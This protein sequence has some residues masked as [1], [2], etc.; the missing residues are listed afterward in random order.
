MPTRIK[1]FFLFLNLNF[2]FLESSSFAQVPDRQ[3]APT[4]PTSQLPS[5]T[6]SSLVPIVV[7]PPNSSPLVAGPPT[8]S[9]AWEIEGEF[10]FDLRLHQKP[11]SLSG[12][13]AFQAPWLS[14]AFTRDFED[15][16]ELIIEALTATPSSGTTEINFRQVAV[17]VPNVIGRSTDLAVGLISNGFFSLQQKFWPNRRTAAEF[18]FPLHRY[19][20]TPDT[21]YGFE[22]QTF[23]S[24]TWTMGLQFSNGE[25]RGKPET[26][27]RKDFSFWLAR[28]WSSIDGRSWLLGLYGV[29]GGYEAIAIDSNNK[30]R[31]QI[32]VASTQSEGFSG[33]AEYSWAWDP[34]DAL[35][36][37]AADQV[38]LT[39]FAGTRVAGIGYAGY[40]SYDWKSGAGTAW[41]IFSRADRW[42]PIKGDGNYAI[43]SSQL[44]VG[45][46]PR[47]TILW[48][49]YNSLTS[50]GQLHSLA[51]RDQ[52]SWRI[53]VDL[54][55][56]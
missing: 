9:S 13:G 7:P 8:A 25:G 54:K 37:V 56:D 19:G 47:D 32:S 50:Y 17:K 27:L 1:I 31:S 53:T 4:P 30:D 36:G 11:S 35:N 6:E 29:R 52:Q 49:L 34:A 23:L 15:E 51:A 48:M 5:K 24:D 45:Y 44:G 46:K 12:V 40:L 42:E 38:N 55:F 21:D 18:A 3:P 16:T 33:G 2:V 10:V 41:S 39:T 22:L 26:G 28:E 20:Y 14:L 43:A